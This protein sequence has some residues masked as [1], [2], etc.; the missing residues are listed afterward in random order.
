[1]VVDLNE[2]SR[3]LIFQCVDLDLGGKDVSVF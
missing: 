3:D 1:M 2:G